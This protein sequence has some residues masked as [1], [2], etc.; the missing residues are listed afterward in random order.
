MPCRERDIAEAVKNA[1]NAGSYSRQV[2]AV[3]SWVPVWQLEE[4][5]GKL[6]VAV[7]PATPVPSSVKRGEFLWDYPM[8][9]GF[10]QQVD[11]LENT[12]I[13]PLADVVQE[14]VDAIKLVRVTLADGTTKASHYATEYMR[15]ADAEFLTEKGLFVSLVQMTYRIVA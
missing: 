12:F 5:R 7:A 6:T 15:H 4:L 2:T 8:V 11:R 9:V 13:D 1:I 10:G 3:R 14:V